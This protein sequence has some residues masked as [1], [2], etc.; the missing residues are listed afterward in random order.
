MRQYLAVFGEVW[1]FMERFGV[2]RGR[3][4]PEAGTYCKPVHKVSGV[5]P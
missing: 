1:T 4:F 2:D 5:V 3:G